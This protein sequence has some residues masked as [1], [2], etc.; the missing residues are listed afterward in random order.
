MPI[1]ARSVQQRARRHALAQVLRDHQRSR[2]LYCTRGAGAPA[3]SITSSL[4]PAIRSISGTTSCSRIPARS[5]R[6]F[7]AHPR[8]VESWY[9]RHIE[10][11]RELAER[12]AEAS[13]A[14]DVER[15]RAVAWWAYEQGERTGAHA[16]IEKDRFVKLDG[17]WRGAMHVVELARVEEG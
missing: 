2:C 4:G 15:T 16:W 8:H 14:C 9:G 5:L 10:R 1:S 12:F 3:T 7:L 6:D 13:V 11:S 17:S